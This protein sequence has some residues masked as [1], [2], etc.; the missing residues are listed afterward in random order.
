MKPHGFVDRSRPL[1]WRESVAAIPGD[2]DPCFA[3]VRD[4]AYSDFGSDHLGD[5]AT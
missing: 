5:E 2:L 3:G 1:S 4:T